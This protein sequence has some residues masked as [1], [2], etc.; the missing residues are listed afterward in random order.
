MLRKLVIVGIVAGGAASVPALYEQNPGLFED[1]VRAVVEKPAA[2]PAPQPP[3]IMVQKARMDAPRDMATGA[4]GRKV[5]IEADD[6]GH[7]QAEAR[8][9][10]RAVEALVDTGATMVAL[11][12]TTA[13]QVGINLVPADFNREVKTANG[14][15]RAATA[16]I[17]AMQIGRIRMRDVDVMILDDSALAG[18]LVGMSFLARLSSVRIENGT[19]LMEQ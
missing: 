15:A 9:N 11:N 4:T 13:R 19:L 16:K 7:F 18:T 17:E 3:L 5:R 14:M 8:I 6:R 1:L 12:R 2:A 10:G